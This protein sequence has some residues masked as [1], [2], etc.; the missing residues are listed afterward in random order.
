MEE[1][2]QQRAKAIYYH[3]CHVKNKGPRGATD[4]VASSSVA[5]EC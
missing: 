5:T 4:R 1:R 3:R 2:D